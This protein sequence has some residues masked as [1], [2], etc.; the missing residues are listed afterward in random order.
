MIQQKLTCL[1]NRRLQKKNCERTIC[2]RW[3]LKSLRRVALITSPKNLGIQL[4]LFNP[5]Q[6]TRQKEF[7]TK[8]KTFFQIKKIKNQLKIFLFHEPI[9]PIQLKWRRVPVHLLCSSKKEL[10]RLKSEGQIKKLESYVPDCFI[11][12]I[13]INCKIDNS[14]KLALDSKF[15]NNK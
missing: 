6:K 10:L 7:S 12:P 5:S 4:I 8:I 14:I 3:E 1:L 13:I 11:S 9:K 15:I 2:Q